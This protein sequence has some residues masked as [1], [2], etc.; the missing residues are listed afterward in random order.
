M[1]SRSPR[2]AIRTLWSVCALAA[3][4]SLHGPLG[5]TPAGQQGTPAFR[6]SVD[7]IAVDVQVVD[8]NGTPIAALGPADFEVSI[9]GKRRRVVSAEFIRSTTLDGRPFQS[10]GVRP[11]ASNLWSSPEEGA[12]DG[13]TYILA[14]DVGSMTVGDSRAAVGSAVEFINRLLPTDRIGLHTFPI[15]SRVDPTTDHAFV[16]QHVANVVGSL[17]MSAGF[18]SRF[19]LSPSEII[20]INAEA[21]RAGTVTTITPGG[22]GGSMRDEE[23]LLMG[24]AT[25]AIRSVQLRECGMTELRC[26][27]ELRA[28]ALALAFLLEGRATEGLQGIRSLVNLLAEYPGRKTVVLFSS[29][30][31]SSDRPGGKPDLG[32][33]PA[34]LGKD[35]AA[36]NT[37]IYTLY[38]DTHEWRATSAATGRASG[39]PGSRTRD[40]AVQGQV[41][42]EFSGASGGALLRVSTGSGEYALD[43]VLRETSSHYLLGVEPEESDRDGQLREL[44]VK[45]DHDDATVRSR[46]WVVVPKRGES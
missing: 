32:S 29:G 1:T 46:M 2:I 19:N 24:D 6:S 25:D 8:D 30:M 13:R 4:A 12:G 16:R 11:I 23:L 27:D 41:L 21:V 37:T 35:A 36:T 17:A 39:S 22:R 9:S 20:D 34:T 31:L 38:V 7:L 40:L 45:V 42:E 18:D 26:G 44:N 3:A 15:G 14:F 43:R 5:A 28:E 10:E 33:L